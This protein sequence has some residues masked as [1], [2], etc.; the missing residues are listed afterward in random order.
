[1]SDVGRG[2]W[3]IVVCLGMSCQ[4]VLTGVLAGDPPK[5]IVDTR[6]G[7]GDVFEA[8]VYGETGLSGT[9]RI[10]A[11][12]TIVFPLIGKVKVAG[13]TPPE[14]GRSIARMLRKGYLRNPQVSI[15]VKEYHSKRVT[16]FGQVRKPGIVS[17]TDNMTIIQVITQAGGFTEMADRDST[18]VT[19]TQEGRK[20]R[21]RVKVKSIGEGRAQ[22]FMVHPGDIIWVPE[23]MM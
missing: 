6:V 9:Y 15:F 2:L 11:D 8:R 1:M 12:G 10:E 19:R 23:S 20:H 13:K 14:I 4:P 5:G 22:N 17:Y 16:V 7:A 21:I 3:A 18:I